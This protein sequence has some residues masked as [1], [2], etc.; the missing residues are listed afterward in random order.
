[1][2]IGQSKDGSGSPVDELGH[3]YWIAVHLLGAQEPMVEDDKDESKSLRLRHPLLAQ[4]HEQI[5]APGDHVAWK[6]SL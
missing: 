3:E 4:R 2:V 5:Y 6:P 1:M